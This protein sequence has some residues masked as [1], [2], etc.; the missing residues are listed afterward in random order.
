MQTTTGAG[1]WRGVAAWTRR[2]FTLVELLVV[3]AIIAVLA[4]ML[5]PAI[6]SVRELAHQTVCASKL[7]QI[8]LAHAGYQGDWEGALAGRS[9]TL[10]PLF[11]GG[12]TEYARL[13]E[14]LDYPVGESP[15]PMD[16]KPYGLF[17]VCPRNPTGNFNGNIPSWPINGHVDDNPNTPAQ[18]FRLHQ[19]LTP[20]SKVY[21]T[22]GCDSGSLRLRNDGFFNN[23]TAGNISLRH[24]GTRIDNNAL[25]WQYISGVANTLFLDG[26]VQALGGAVFPTIS[27]WPVGNQWLANSTPP[28]NW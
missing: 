22:D 26:H 28:G 15:K 12:S 7:R 19:F 25:N 23:P 14:Y 17:L 4:G 9:P 16:R 5:L 2:A 24:H 1:S 6:G 10:A 27:S 18:P 20:A 21:A 11:V 8:G 13:A 3:I